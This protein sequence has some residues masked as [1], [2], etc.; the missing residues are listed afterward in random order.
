MF[1]KKIDKFLCSFISAKLCNAQA[2]KE[3]A[4][5]QQ[6]ERVYKLFTS[7]LCP[8]AQNIK[9]HAMLIIPFSN[10]ERPCP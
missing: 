5:A 4:T 2:K 9:S 6:F 7:S 1:C 3:S 10:T 8:S